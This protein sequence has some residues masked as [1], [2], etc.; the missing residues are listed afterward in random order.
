VAL[1]GSAGRAGGNGYLVITME[2][3]GVFVNQNGVFYS[4]KEI[5]VKDDGI[6]K[7]TNAVYLNINGTWQE[8]AGPQITNFTS[9]S[10][11]FG[12]VPRSSPYTYSPPP[13][14]S[15]GNSPGRGGGYNEGNEGTFGTQYSG[16]PAEGGDGHSF[17]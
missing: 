10:G 17:G 3:P 16:N 8:A 1:G 9:V 6:W 11:G 7:R 2:V 14:P 12:M 13:E 4:T 15:P 5:Y